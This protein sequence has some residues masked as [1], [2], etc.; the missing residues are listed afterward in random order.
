MTNDQI[1]KLS[2]LKEF[3]AHAQVN[4]SPLKVNFTADEM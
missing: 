4:T 2:P 1:Q 3:N